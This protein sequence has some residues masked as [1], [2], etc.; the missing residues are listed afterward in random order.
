MTIRH[1]PLKHQGRLRV[2][3]LL[4][5]VK[6]ENVAGMIKDGQHLIVMS[7]FFPL[8]CG[9]SR[10][11]ARSLQKKLYKNTSTWTQVVACSVANHKNQK[12]KPKQKTQGKTQIPQPDLRPAKQTAKGVRAQQKQPQKRFAKDTVVKTHCVVTDSK[13]CSK[14]ISY[15]PSVRHA[16]TLL[17]RRQKRSHWLYT[18]A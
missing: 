16:I 9:R 4:C 12:H 10:S 15:H 1:K 17:P 18:I 3:M 14:R 2:D 7:F 6:G 8:W 5:H 13:T 11:K